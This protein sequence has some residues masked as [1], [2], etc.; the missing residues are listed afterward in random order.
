MKESFILSFFT[1]DTQAE[2]F[3]DELGSLL[4]EYSHP[5][6]PLFYKDTFFFLVS[7]FLFP[8]AVVR[9]Q[10]SGVLWFLV[11]PLRALKKTL[12]GSHRCK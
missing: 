9:A 3:G 10:G 12:M 6:I 1:L 7:S 8:E 5:L 4:A 11:P 2:A